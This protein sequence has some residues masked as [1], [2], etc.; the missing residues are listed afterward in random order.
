MG[1]IRELLIKGSLWGKKQTPED[2]AV[3]EEQAR[4][5]QEARA[6]I[7]EGTEQAR[8]LG[9]KEYKEVGLRTGIYGSFPLS[10]GTNLVFYSSRSRLHHNVVNSWTYVIQGTVRYPE[11]ILESSETRSGIKPTHVNIDYRKAEERSENNQAALDG[12]KGILE[13]FKTAS[14]LETVVYMSPV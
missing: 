8:L 7:L 14:P 4:I 3:R 11:K 12:T 2:H 1:N 10:D 13:K 6:L 5:G 9:A